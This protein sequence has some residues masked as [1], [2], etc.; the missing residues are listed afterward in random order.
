VVLPAEFQGCSKLLIIST[1]LLIT[2]LAFAT[3]PDLP[4][5]DLASFESDGCTNFSD[6]NDRHPQL[7]LHCCYRHDMLYWMGGTELQREFA[8]EE[9]KQCVIETEEFETANLMYEAVR[10]GGSPY[11]PTT[12]RWGFGWQEMRGYAPLTQDEAELV[13]KRVSR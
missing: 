6:G 13:N 12:W 7:W 3:T 4:Y 1:I 9:L 5:G 10:I 11:L 2:T 8:D